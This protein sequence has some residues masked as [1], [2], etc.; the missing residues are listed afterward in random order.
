MANG[1]PAC[2]HAGPGRRGSRVSGGGVTT[3]GG[4]LGE[5]LLRASV[6]TPDTVMANPPQCMEL[7]RKK[8]L[9]RGTRTETSAR[10]RS[11]GKAFLWIRS[12]FGGSRA[13]NRE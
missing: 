12:E 11:R 5:G 6:N 8:K 7:L 3:H 9:P 2:A 10:E 13:L 1:P 4:G